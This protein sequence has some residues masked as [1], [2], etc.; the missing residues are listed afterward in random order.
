M[1]LD[2]MLM[3]FTSFADLETRELAKARHRRRRRR[4]RL[5]FHLR[6]GNWREKQR[7]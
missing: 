1:S 7:R 6:Q 4:R 5:T 2:V 3:R